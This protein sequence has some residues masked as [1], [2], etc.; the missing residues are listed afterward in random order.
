MA[1]RILFVSYTADWVGPTNSLLLLLKY[2]QHRYDV[3]VMMPGEGEFSNT[4]EQEGIPFFNIS[5]TKWSIPAI[6]RLFR[7]EQFDLIY[8]NNNSSCSRNAFIAAKTTHIP[9]I[10][11][12]REMGWNHTWKTMGYLRFA[13]GV[14]AVSQACADSIKRFVVNDRLY[15]VNN[16]VQFDATLIDHQ[17]D[18]ARLLKKTD[19]SPD[20]LIIVGVSHLCPRKG[21][22]YAVK[23]MASVVR[24]N[25]SIRLL[26]VGSQERDIEYVQ[27]LNLMIRQMNLEKNI[28][29][30]GFLLDVVKLLPGADIFLHT[31]ISDP[32]PRSVIEAMA[33]ELPVVSFAVDG[34]IDT[35]IDNQTGYLV[36]VKDVSGLADAILKLAKDKSLRDEFGHNGRIRA[37]DHFSAEKTAE[38]VSDII[39]KV[40]ESTKR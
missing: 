40:L 14:I 13:H 19:L 37:R 4:L 23:A 6:I 21:Q 34:V 9:Y 11:H 25:H 27:K 1:K 17:S 28:F 3:A 8:G 30:V 24:E 36:E 22:E 12:I 38:Q 7:Q 29:L 18:R 5:M 32:H 33:A 2:L 20:E 15:V 16:G 31:A 10:G 35:V 39:D 26:L